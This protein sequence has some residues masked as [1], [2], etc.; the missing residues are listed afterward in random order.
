MRIWDRLAHGVNR[1]GHAALLLGF[2]RDE[3]ELLADREELADRLGVTRPRVDQLFY[4]VRRFAQG[5]HRSR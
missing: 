2:L 5:G 4:T 3:P 1:K